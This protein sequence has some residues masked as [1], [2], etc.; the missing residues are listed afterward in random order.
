[1]ASGRDDIREDALAA[2][3]TVFLPFAEQRSL[4]DV[5]KRLLF[6]RQ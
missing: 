5:V 1:M 2:G 4:G 3:V 6:P